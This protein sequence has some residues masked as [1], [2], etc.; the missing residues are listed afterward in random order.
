MTKLSPTPSSGVGEES[1]E[2][3]EPVAL[4]LA[5]SVTSSSS[6][7]GGQ[8]QQARLLLDASP[9]VT[10][11]H[12]T[13]RVE[14]S[15]AVM[16]DTARRRELS[17]EVSRLQRLSHDSSRASYTTASHRDAPVW[18]ER[19]RAVARS[20]RS[21][22]ALLHAQSLYCYEVQRECC[23]LSPL[24]VS[25]DLTAETNAERRRLAL[26]GERLVEQRAYDWELREAEAV[27]IRE[28]AKPR[29]ASGWDEVDEAHRLRDPPGDRKSVV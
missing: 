7:S 19:Q 28:E 23:E 21:N 14:D 1:I 11:Q 3:G 26:E 12:G 17:E 18:L 9:H 8:Q 2:E 6:S 27:R 22:K 10:F 16:S 29:I 20:T 15:N 4:N 5:E 24:K 13:T 25:V